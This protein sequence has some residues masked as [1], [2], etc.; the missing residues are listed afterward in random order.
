MIEGYPWFNTQ[1]QAKIN[2]AVIKVNSLRFR[3][4]DP[5]VKY[6]SRKWRNG[7]SVYSVY[8]SERCLRIAMIRIA[9]N[10]PVIIIKY[11][12]LF[13]RERIPDGR[14]FS[15][16]VIPSFYLVGSGGNPHFEN[17]PQN[18]F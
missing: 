2:D 17:L 5:L 3:A 13:M 7:S 16:G 1:L 6:G 9:G 18:H 4:P 15:I 11:L 12:F 14:T 8:R 10:I